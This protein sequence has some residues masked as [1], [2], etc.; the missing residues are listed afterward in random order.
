MERPIF[1]AIGTPVAELDTPALV[2][3]LAVLERNIEVLHSFFRQS[4]AK[5]RPHIESHRCP[6]IAHL[7]LAGG[8]TVGGI[9]A[10]TVGEAEVFAENGIKDIFVANEIVSPQ[11]IRRLCTLA[12]YARVMVAVDNPKNVQDLSQAATSSGITLN[13]AVDINTRLNRC[14]VEPGLP[15]VDLATAVSKASGLRFMGLMTYEGT[16]LGEDPDEVAAESRKWV[17]QVLDTR[18]MVEKAGMEVEVVSVGGTYNYEIAGTMAGVTEVPAGSYA[19]MDQRYCQYGGPFQP[20]ARVMATVTSH[21]EPETVITDC[22]QKAI[23]ADSGDPVIADVAGATVTNLSAE[24]GRLH[25]EGD[26]EGEIDLGDKVW[27]TPWDVGTCVNLHD[28][29]HVVRDG[30]LVAMWNVAARGR[31]R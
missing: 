26:A 12:D 11:K 29:I 19:L 20:A 23:G 8:G 13:V 24:H 5:V 17:Q 31:Y 4:Q 27:L 7:Q 1:K 18:Q 25:L 21:P 3:D 2:V 28:Y 9:S 16:I 10:T 30:K 15:A 6:D 14:G 22:G